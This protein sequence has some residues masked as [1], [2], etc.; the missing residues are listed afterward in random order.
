MVLHYPIL[1][2]SSSSVW[3]CSCI[4]TYARRT[5]PFSSLE[6]LV[7]NPALKLTAAV[8]AWCLQVVWVLRVSQWVRESQKILQEKKKKQLPQYVQQQPKEQTRKN[9]PDFKKVSQHFQ[10]SGSGLVIHLKLSKKPAISLV[11]LQVICRTYLKWIC[12]LKGAW[13]NHGK[14]N[15]TS[16]NP[17]PSAPHIS[18][19]AR[20]GTRR[21]ASDG[22]SSTVNRSHVLSSSIKLA[23]SFIQKCQ[24]LAQHLSHRQYKLILFSFHVMFMS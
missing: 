17:H 21:R 11:F 8:T 6:E 4:H 1:F 24:Q 5:N 16:S 22:Q 7:C 23:S 13:R 2:V 12:V 10:I 15:P 9:H 3:F 20:N 18:G 19:C 14:E